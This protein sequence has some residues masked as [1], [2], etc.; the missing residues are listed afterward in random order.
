VDGIDSLL[1]TAAV[2]I[3]GTIITNAVGKWMARKSEASQN[4]A[5]D[6]DAAKDVSEAVSILIKPL[7]DELALVQKENSKL[8]SRVVAMED[9]VAGL[10][11]DLRRASD[12]FEYIVN[13]SRDTFPEHVE[14]AI[15]IRKGDS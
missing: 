10:K 11:L 7:R 9:E 8:K 6:G 4:R 1:L 12:A 13:V 15:R 14:R 2:S 3:G 5:L